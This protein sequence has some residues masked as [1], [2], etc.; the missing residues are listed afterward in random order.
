MFKK[1][2]ATAAFALAMLAVVAP[3]DA[4]QRGQRGQG[5]QGSMDDRMARMTEALSLTD[6]QVGPVRAVFEMQAERAQELRSSA[7]G[8]REAMRAA[9][10]DMQEETNVQ[11]A[12]IL[13]EDQMKKYTELMAS[14]RRGPPPF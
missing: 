9:M 13:T 4:Q 11:L 8:D 10:M 5:G 3:L 1:N 6:E 7:G 12:D 2:L 14:R